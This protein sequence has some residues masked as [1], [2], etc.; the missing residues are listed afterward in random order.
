MTVKDQVS[1]IDM[2]YRD[3]T[4]SVEKYLSAKPDMSGWRYLSGLNYGDP[5]CGI[6]V[7]KRKIVAL[8]RE[9]MRLSDALGDAQ[10]EVKK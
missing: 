6:S 2:M 4:A 1:Y 8:R 9:L 5:D 3:M 7:L 10:A